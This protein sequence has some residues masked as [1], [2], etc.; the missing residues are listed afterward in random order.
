MLKIHQKQM[1]AFQSLAETEFVKR[2]VAAVR[3]KH[4]AVAVRLPN[5]SSTVAQLSDQVLEEMV[6]NGIARA[7]QYDISYES[8]LVA[9]VVTMFE[10]APN[11][12]A[13]P[14]MRQVLQDEKNAPNSRMDLLLDQAAEQ[15]WEAIKSNYDPSA[16]QLTRDQAN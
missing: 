15:D 11:F 16:W 4:A 9:F 1:L 3:D 12:D 14:P 10:A 6:Q 13:H 2:V 5:S 8:A 7:R